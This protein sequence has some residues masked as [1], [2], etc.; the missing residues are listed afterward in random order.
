MELANLLDQTRERI[1]QGRLQDAATL[2]NIG[3]IAF[4]RHPALIAL[5]KALPGQYDATFFDD[6]Y[7]GS[8]RS[9]AL[10][11]RRLRVF[12][13]FTSMVDVGAGAGAWSHAA[14]DAGHKVLSVDG[15]WSQTI[16]K[17][18]P[19]LEYHY[20]DLNQ[21]IAL[22][23]RFDLAL[24]VEVAEHLEPSRSASF[25]AD[26]CQLAPVVV[27]GAALPRQGGC[28]HINCR[29]HSY[30]IEQFRHHHFRAVDLF[31]PVFWYDGRVGPW[32]AQNTYLFVAETM[33]AAFHGLPVPSL[34]DVYHPR[35]VLDSPVCLQDHVNARIDPGNPEEAAA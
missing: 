10:F 4:P 31:R 14:L 24:S 17:P 13:A 23:Q 20:Q 1:A 7:A 35:V 33:A 26:L 34:V 2:V 3:L 16:A 5:F 19:R 6:A 30:W 21:R 11:L 28:G 9:A 18:C 22:E 27:F 12:Y 8:H 15:A 29:P 32:Y 25:V